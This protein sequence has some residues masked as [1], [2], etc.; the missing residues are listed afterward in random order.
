MV[1]SLC[2]D[3]CHSEMLTSSPFYQCAAQWAWFKGRAK[4]LERNSRVPEYSYA[5]SSSYGALGNM[6]KFSISSCVYELIMLALHGSYEGS[7]III[8]IIISTLIDHLLWDRYY[9]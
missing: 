3:T 4:A 9:A 6:N 1:I 5:T 2:L 8:I 7:I